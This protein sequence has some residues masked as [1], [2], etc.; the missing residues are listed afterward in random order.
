MEMEMEMDV[1]MEMKMD[2]GMEDGCRREG[3]CYSLTSPRLIILIELHQTLGED[4]DCDADLSISADVHH[5][6]DGW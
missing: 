6:D 5:N 3:N 4:V 2:M 1:E